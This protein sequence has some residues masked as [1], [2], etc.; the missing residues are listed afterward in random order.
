[1][2]IAVGADQQAVA[3]TQFGSDALLQILHRDSLARQLVREIGHHAFTHEQVKGQVVHLLAAPEEVLRRVD[4]AAGVQ[5]H[6]HA[7]HH[8]PQ[9]LVG[10]VRFHQFDLEL[11]VELEA[12][13]HL[14]LE[15]LVI[16]LQ[17][18][19]HHPAGT[20]LHV[21]GIAGH[22]AGGVSVIHCATPL[23]IHWS[24]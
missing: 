15:S 5:A 21:H 10:I 12:I 8:L 16:Q 1:M 24:V 3:R 22:I 14:H 9:A 23:W 4:M 18:D 19:I 20:Q 11:H 17:A 6:V 2:I 7:A 13:Q